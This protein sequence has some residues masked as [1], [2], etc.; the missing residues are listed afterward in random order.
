MTKKHISSSFKSGLKLFILAAVVLGVIGILGWSA[1]LMTPGKRSQQLVEHAREMMEAE[2]WSESVV[3]LRKA[4]EIYPDDKGIRHML[5]SSLFADG[6]VE[7]GLAEME[8]LLLQPPFGDD[9]HRQR[10]SDYYGTVRDGGVKLE[11]L[12]AMVERM[13]QSL[14]QNAQWMADMLDARVA[15]LAGEYEQSAAKFGKLAD[16]GVRNYKLRLDWAQSLL[17]SGKAE[18]AGV[19]FRD[20][21]KAD[22]NSIDALNGYATALTL[23]GKADDA[24]DVFI[25]ASLVGEPPLLQALLNGGMFAMNRG[26]VAEAGTYFMNRLAKYYPDDRQGVLMRMRY[27]V[28]SGDK[29]SFFKLLGTLKPAIDEPEIASIEQWCVDR[30]QPVWGLELL[31]AHA[32]QDMD[33]DDIT[34]YRISA[35]LALR[36]FDEALKLAGSIKDKDRQ[37]LVLAELDLRSGKLV[38]AEGR[39]NALVEADKDDPGS[40]TARA[41]QGLVRLRAMQKALDAAELLPRA[42]I[43]LGQGRGE[44]V[45]TLLEGVKKPDA[46]LDMVGVMALMQLDRKQEAMNRLE[47][48]RK[49]YPVRE[50]IWLVWGRAVAESDPQ[51]ALSGLLDAKLT[52]ADGPGL[53]SLIGELQYKLGQQQEAISTWERLALRWPNTLAGNV[54]NVFRAQAYMVLKDWAKAADVWNQVLKIA[55]NDPVTLNNLA[56]S[57][58]QGDGDLQQAEQLAAKALTIKPGDAAIADTLAEVRKARA[59]GTKNAGG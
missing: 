30:G 40:I 45:L 1:W 56:Y 29:A 53:E 16:A 14:P 39:L 15:F 23:Q 36:R 50:D 59:S 58:L 8:T 31:D 44:E 6:K 51:K 5:M 19:L 33:R 52:S 47:V 41:E 4:L 43:L 22:S 46:D 3:A 35:M 54:S 42:R 48:L 37:S 32:P 10:F 34:T 11:R 26:R 25:R 20:M 18:E 24:L 21:L 28:L 55:P 9:A 17:A 49:T 27:D 38:E 13:H 7:Q 57:L 2:A 12:R